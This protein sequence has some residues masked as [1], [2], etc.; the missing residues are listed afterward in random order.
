[1]KSTQSQRWGLWLEEHCPGDCFVL[2]VLTC[3]PLYLKTS[4]LKQA[5]G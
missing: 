2:L 4:C 1:M 3:V 5:L